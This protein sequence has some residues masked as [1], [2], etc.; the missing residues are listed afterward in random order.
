MLSMITLNNYEKDFTAI[1]AIKFSSIP[2]LSYAL[3][4]IYDFYG[5]FI[6]SNLYPSLNGGQSILVERM[7]KT[8]YV[9]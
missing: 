3:W 9:I 7:S 5:L 1:K 8:R 4:F 6:T 2:I